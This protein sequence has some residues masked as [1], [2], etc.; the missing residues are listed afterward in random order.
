MILINRHLFIG[1]P[2]AIINPKGMGKR[3]DKYT[4]DGGRDHNE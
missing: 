4:N 2:D 1:E 3:C